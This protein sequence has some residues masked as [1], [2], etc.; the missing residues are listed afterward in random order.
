MK[1]GRSSGKLAQRISQL[2]LP[3][4]YLETSQ[5]QLPL[6]ASQRA[7]CPAR[8]ASKPPPEHLPRDRS[9]DADI[10]LAHHRAEALAVATHQRRELFGRGR[11]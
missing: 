10:G 1:F 2:E 5:A 9:I 11:D 7:P 4:E 3:L 8:P 6:A